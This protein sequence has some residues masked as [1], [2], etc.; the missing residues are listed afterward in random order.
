MVS[1]EL[2]NVCFSI[3]YIILS[4]LDSPYMKKDKKVACMPLFCSSRYRQL[5]L[6]Y[7]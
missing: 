5:V 3:L 6:S 1:L 7:S 4:I 2:Y